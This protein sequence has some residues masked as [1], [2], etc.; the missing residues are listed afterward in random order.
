[1]E[2]RHA[3]LPARDHHREVVAERLADRTRLGTGAEPGHLGVLH[4]V[5]VLVHDHLGVLAVV[6]AALADRDEVALVVAEEGVVAAELVDAQLD[7]TLV[8]RPQ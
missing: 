7:L 2:R 5:P 6:D 1:M 4:R 3:G 8:D